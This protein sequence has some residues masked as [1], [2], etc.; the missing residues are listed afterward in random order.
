[1]ARNR[2]VLSE[3]RFRWEVQTWKEEKE[4]NEHKERE[5]ELSSSNCSRNILISLKGR[6]PTWRLIRPFSLA[7][8]CKVNAIH[9]SLEA[10]EKFETD[11]QPNLS[12]LFSSSSF[13][14]T[15]AF[16]LL[17]SLLVSHSYLKASARGNRNGLLLQ[18][19]D[20]LRRSVEVVENTRSLLYM[21]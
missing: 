19:G 2:E 9:S 17:R 10:S 4:K 8:P 11:R 1:M 20:W 7:K 14:A 15:N 5:G 12:I 13:L 16:P 18:C 3:V 21:R 6:W